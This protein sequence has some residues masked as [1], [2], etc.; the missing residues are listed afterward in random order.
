M[1]QSFI[2]LLAEMKKLGF[3]TR[4]KIMYFT[5]DLNEARRFNF[6]QT[7]WHE[8]PDNLSVMSL[9]CILTSIQTANAVL[10]GPSG[11]QCL[12]M[13]HQLWVSCCFYGASQRDETEVGAKTPLLA[14]EMPSWFD[15]EHRGEAERGFSLVPSDVTLWTQVLRGFDI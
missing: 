9:N 8:P 13:A 10:S 6:F 15:N 4:G 2:G 1:K 5:Y 7:I 3:V 11:G 12:P 14:T